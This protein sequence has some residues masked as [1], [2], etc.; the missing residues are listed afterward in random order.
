MDEAG[1][2]IHASDNDITL[3]AF[4]ARFWG[5]EPSEEMLKGS[6]KDCHQDPRELSGQRM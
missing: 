3:S 2:L 1:D 5:C 4:A 6:D